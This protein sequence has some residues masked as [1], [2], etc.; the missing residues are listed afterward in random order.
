MTAFNPQPG[1]LVFHPD[2][3]GELLVANKGEKFFTCQKCETR[4]SARDRERIIGD[5]QRPGRWLPMDPD[6]LHPPPPS[7]YE[8]PFD[9][10]VT[11]FQRAF[12]P[13]LAVIEASSK[14][15]LL[16]KARQ[17][18]IPYEA[19]HAFFDTTQTHGL[20]LVKR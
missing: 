20:R 9:N 17:L 13:N 6:P 18:G 10:R 19:A 14:A 15:D 2:C 12:F 11:P 4:V 3:G 8:L 5:F 1:V 7:L 16:E